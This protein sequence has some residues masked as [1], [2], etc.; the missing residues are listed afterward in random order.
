MI[1]TRHNLEPVPATE[2]VQLLADSLGIDHL[3]D[4]TEGHYLIGWAGETVIAN[5]YDGP[6]VYQSDTHTI[7]VFYG[8]EDEPNIAE[9]LDHADLD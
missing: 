4:V 8:E 2:A 7:V 3:D 5:P 9:V 6:L 1:I